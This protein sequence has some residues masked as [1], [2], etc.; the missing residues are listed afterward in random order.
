MKIKVENSSKKGVHLVKISGAVKSGDEFEIG[1]VIDEYL[2]LKEVPKFIFDLKKV[3]FINSAAL[4]MFLQIFKRIE[5]RKGRLVFTNLT[6]AV[7]NVMD[8]TQLSSVFQIDE[9][10]DEALQTFED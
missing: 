3:T 10:L 8:I 6:A 1:E 7:K 9:T 4:G 5:S 2:A